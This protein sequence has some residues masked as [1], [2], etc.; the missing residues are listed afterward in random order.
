MGPEYCVEIEPHDSLWQVTWIK[1]SLRY[2]KPYFL[3]PKDLIEKAN[4]V[5]VILERLVRLVTDRGALT[6]QSLAEAVAILNELMAEGHRLY[7]LL[8][9]DESQTAQEMADRIRQT[10]ADRTDHPS[11]WFKVTSEVTIPWALL[12]EAPA[13]ETSG[14]SSPDAYQSFWALKYS[15][16]TLYHPLVAPDQFKS[17]YPASEFDTLM[18]VDAGFHGKARDQLDAKCPEAQLFAQLHARVDDPG[19]LLAEWTR[20]ESRLGLL[21]LYCHSSPDTIGFSFE[22]LKRVNFKVDFKKRTVPPPCLVFLNGCHTAAG[23]FFA[24]TGQSGFCGL[25]GAETVVP[26]MFAHRFGAA[27]IASLYAG[28]SLGSSFDRL[29][30]LHWPLSLIYGLY[31]Y[32]LLQLEPSFKTPAFSNTNYSTLSVGD[33]TL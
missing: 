20:R 13:P 24:T 1:N 18:G 28:E 8:F 22:A 23:R 25:I 32:P 27:L 9:T 29:R 31:A 19:A 3:E 30:R 14:T 26:Y 2:P 33:E 12:S 7:Q 11:I 17:S 15:I 10:L 16:A 5:R 21:Y 6:D 4:D